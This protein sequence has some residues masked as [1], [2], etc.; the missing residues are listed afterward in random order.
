MPRYLRYTLLTIAV[1]TMV[2]WVVSQF[3]QPILPMH[4]NQALLLLGVVLLTVIATLAN[5]KSALD[6]FALLFERHDQNK[7]KSIVVPL[8]SGSRPLV[9]ISGSKLPSDPPD[10]IARF[11]EICEQIGELLAELGCGIIG[12]P[13]HPERVLASQSAMR[14]LKRVNPD[15]PTF[16]AN[17]R[18]PLNAAERSRFVQFASAGIFV[19]GTGGTL[20]EFELLHQAGIKP[21]IPVSGAGGTGAVLARQ[22][23][24]G[25]NPF[26]SAKLGRGEIE[27]LANP[28]Q[29]PQQYVD[30][31]RKILVAH[32][33][34]SPV[35]DTAQFYDTSR[36]E[37]DR[38]GDI[39]FLR[40]YGYGE[41]P[42][43]NIDREVLDDY[44]YSDQSEEYDDD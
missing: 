16:T 39:F 35:G 38:S 7:K 10:Q 5:L 32:K 25:T 20:Q 33:L 34:K 6:L 12:C 18:F 24:G 42:V 1:L 4:V 26:V 22:M 2:I 11:C 31:I 19:G 28:S 15:A 9:F 44:I 13:P 17:V 29:S 41:D 37:P 21:L 40:A 27:T 30:A 14:G 8:N 36:S 23:L 3:V 43:P